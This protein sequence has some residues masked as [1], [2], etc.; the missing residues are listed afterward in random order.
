MV[1]C[2][3][4][5]G[6][7]SFDC[8]GTATSVTTADDED[9]ALDPSS[10]IVMSL[11]LLLLLVQVPLFLL[12]VQVPLFHTTTDAAVGRHTWDKSRHNRRSTY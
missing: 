2:T 8:T 6:D 9:V 10:E 11:S 12:L 1:D 5:D 4:G 3:A 7:E